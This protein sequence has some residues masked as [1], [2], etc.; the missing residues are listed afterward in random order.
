[1]KKFIQIISIALVGILAASCAQKELTIFHPDQMKGGQLNAIQGAYVLSIDDEASTFETFTFD[2]STYGVNCP[3]QYGLWASLSEDFTAEKRMGTA[4]SANYKD[5]IAVTV[6]AMN[7]QLISWGCAA[8]A[9]AKVYFRLKSDMMGEKSPIEGTTI[10]SNVISTQITPYFAEK[11]YK[12]FGV[13]GN[14]QG[15]APDGYPRL[16]CYMEDDDTYSG[17]IDFQLTEG[18]YASDGF[19]I[20]EGAWDDDKTFGGPGDGLTPEQEVINLQNP[21]NDIKCYGEKR[22]YFFTFKKEA[23]TLTKVLSFDKV[24]VIGLNGDWD[25]DVEMTFNIYKDRFYADVD[26]PANTEFK[27]R[28]DGG[29]DVNWGGDKDNLSKGGANIPIEAGQYRIYFYMSTPQV[30]CE[31]DAN[32]YG[33][34]EPGPNPGPDPPTPAYQGWGLIGDFNEWAGDVE[35][36]EASGV[37]TGYTTI[38]KGQGFKIRKDAAWDDNRGA[39]GDVEPFEVTLGEPINVVNGGKNLTVPADGFYKVVYDSTN[40][41][42]TVSDGTVWGVIGDFNSWAGD[43]FMAEAGGVWTSPAIELEA[44]KGFKIRK[45]SAWNENRGATGETEPYE[46]TPGTPIAVVNNGKNLTVPANGKYVVI[47]N[48]NDETITVNQA[49]PSNTWSLIGVNGDWD[50]DIFMSELMPGVWVSPATAMGG[51][52]KLRFNHDWGVNRGCASLTLGGPAQEATQDGPNITVEEG[53]YTVVY[54]ANMEIIYLQGWALIGTLNGTNWDTDFPVR[55]LEVDENTVAWISYP[56]YVDETQEF[57]FRFNSSWDINK[58]GDFT[59][60]CVPF[61]AVD[62]GNNIKI[63]QAGYY[64][65]AYNRDTEELGVRRADWGVI[66][67]FNSWGGD[68][69]MFEQ[70]PGIYGTIAPV[71]LEAG[72][73]F[74]IRK[75]RDWGVNRGATGDVEPFEVTPGTPLP[76]IN[77]GKNLTVAT[78]GDYMIMYNMNTEEI[79]VEALSL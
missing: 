2:E 20:A 73:G 17:V 26:V 25:N 62:G 6:K 12:W 68:V 27:F 13:P 65:A 37:W 31:L 10:I 60:F 3:V 30:H 54:D 74:K 16:Y 35:M 47:Y 52:F 64:Y 21:G 19:K 63:G 18:K 24:G 1:M 72:K 15:W 22:Y 56:F 7:N 33:K 55:P 71:T 58:G 11:E 67:D 76:V 32:M 51:E 14:Y 69:V 59:D 38:A 50:N 70:E 39:E 5:G 45:N 79:V 9:P 34:E 42:M 75:D 53:T 36:T 61:A 23:K 66:G 4:A 49:L 28:L 41:T 44:G 57:K 77:N 8:D 29:W 40:E 48:A 43:V 46:I 78:T